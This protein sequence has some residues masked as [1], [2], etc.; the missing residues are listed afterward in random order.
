M[1]YKL[2]KM[3]CNYIV[4]KGGGAD[5]RQLNNKH[6]VNIFCLLKE[7]SACL[8]L[9]DECFIMTELNAISFLRCL[10]RY[11]VLNQLLAV[12]GKLLI[13]IAKG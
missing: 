13:L 10:T 4:F 7:H 9:R 6:H 8:L 1:M 11:Y 2:S 12:I 3:C 5:K